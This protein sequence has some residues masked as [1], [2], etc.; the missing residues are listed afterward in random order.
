M[1]GIAFNLFRLLCTMHAWLAPPQVKPRPYVIRI[2]TFNM[3]FMTQG[4]F[5]TSITMH[6]MEVATQEKAFRMIT[7]S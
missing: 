7:M 2:Y 4:W 5:Q 3:S 6:L 1:Q